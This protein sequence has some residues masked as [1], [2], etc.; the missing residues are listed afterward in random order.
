[1]LPLLVFIC[2]AH[3]QLDVKED[4]RSFSDETS[5]GPGSLAYSKRGLCSAMGD[6]RLI[7]MMMMVAAKCGRYKLDREDNK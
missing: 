7:M 6:Y 4:R 5:M 2:N 1:M 3:T